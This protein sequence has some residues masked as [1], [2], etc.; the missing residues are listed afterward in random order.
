VE[1][2]NQP[3]IIYED[4]F[5]L[6]IDKPPGWVVNRAESAHGPVLQDWI[7]ENFE[8]E[9]AKNSR[10]RSGII[11][12]LD[13]ETSGVLLVSKTIESFGKL[14]LLFKKREIEKSY[15]ALVHGL[16]ELKSGQISAPIGRLPWNR[17]R[18]GILP[19]GRKAL[20][21]YNVD[22][23]YKRGEQVLS[24]MNIY[25]KT[26]R[27]HQIRVHLKS[28]QH[29]IVSDFLYAGRKTAR[30]DRV[31]CPRLFLHAN[32]IRFEN[33]MTGKTL[34]VFSPLPSDLASALATLD[35]LV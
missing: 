6:A 20:T 34:T 26:G 31:W 2:T 11:H 28:I 18:F 16:V 12:R 27:T 21:L 14:Q 24:L 3:R 1:Q 35:K 30:E 7:E 25:P 13:K 32:S 17:E 5:L 23:Y 4:D 19:N 9:T 33:P 15:M 8:F 29:P 22:S 10:L